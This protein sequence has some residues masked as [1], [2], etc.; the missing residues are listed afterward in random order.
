MPNKLTN[1]QR[2]E[3]VSLYYQLS[4]HKVAEIFNQRYPN[5]RPLSH[6]TVIKNFNKFNETGAVYDRKRSGRPK[7]SVTDENAESV[8][9]LV[10]LEPKTNIRTLA[11]EVD[12]S[13]SSLRTILKKYKFHPYKM[14]ILQQ[15]NPGDADKRLAFTNK[16]IDMANHDPLFPYNIIWTDESIFTLKGIMNKQNYR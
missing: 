10:A 15:L 16:F 5:R 8:L 3:I 7:T 6:R 4:L 11:R 14:K 12:I 13:R 1:A 9:A 2:T